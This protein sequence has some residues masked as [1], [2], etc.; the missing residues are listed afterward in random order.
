MY[1]MHSTETEGKKASAR[2]GLKNGRKAKKQKQ[3]NNKQNKKIKNQICCK[4]KTKN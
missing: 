1:G 3:Q 4:K 2:R